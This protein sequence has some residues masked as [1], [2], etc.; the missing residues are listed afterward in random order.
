MDKMTNKKALM[1]VKENFVD[2]PA[3]VAERIDAM[4]TSLDKKSAN[5]KPTKTQEENEILKNAIADALTTEGKTPSDFIKSVPELSG[6]TPQK[7]SPLLYQLVADGRAKKITD[8]KR[9]LF[10]VA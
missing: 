4:I 6:M 9:S 1:W 2:M 5:R 7:V 10:A 8:K 3:D